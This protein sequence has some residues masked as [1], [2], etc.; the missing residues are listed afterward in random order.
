MTL[1]ESSADMIHRV[2]S[3]TVAEGVETEAMAE[4]MLALGTDYLQGMFYSAPMQIGDFLNKWKL[5]QS[6]VADN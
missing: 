5:F 2:G 6:D 1:L 3:K 4:K